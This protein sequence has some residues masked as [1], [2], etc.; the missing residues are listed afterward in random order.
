MLDTE[1]LKEFKQKK[2]RKAELKEEL[3]IV[4][5]ELGLLEGQI[6]NTFADLGI[7]SIKPMAQKILEEQGLTSMITLNYQSLSAYIREIVKSGEDLP[8]EFNGVI[9][10]HDKMSL[11]LTK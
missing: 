8:E 5:E 10:Y 9:S 6:I 2:E 4:E 3:R 1:V 11:R 7:G